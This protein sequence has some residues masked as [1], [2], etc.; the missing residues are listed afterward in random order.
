MNSTERVR[1][2]ILGQETDRQPIYGWVSANLSNEITAAYG[3]I[4]SFVKKQL[5][6]D[7]TEF[8]NSLRIFIADQKIGRFCGG[9]VH[10]SARSKAAVLEARSPLIL[11]RCTGTGK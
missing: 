5:R 4:Y 10:K 9:P 11:D 6:S 1:R 7:Q 3:K 2:T 8:E